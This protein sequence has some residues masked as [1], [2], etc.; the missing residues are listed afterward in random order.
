[1]RRLGSILFLWLLVLVWLFPAWFGLSD[2]RMVHRV[3][4]SAIRVRDGDTV[5]VDGQ[6][7]RLHGIDAPEL[8]QTCKTAAGQ[9]WPCGKDARAE[10]GKLIGRQS[11][12]CEERARD[13][14]G[15]IVA[16]CMGDGGDIAAMLVARGFAVSFGGFADGPYAAEEGQA[17]AS[18][19]G[20]WQGAFDPPSS[21]R[22][23]HPR[24]SAPPPVANR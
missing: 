6:D 17:K 11:L 1:M 18:G 14:Y 8:G 22:S 5:T 4:G 2:G 10:L 12:R 16:T 7:Y 20:L 13:R 19:R 24:E 15:R 3:E 21:W 9:D 23:A